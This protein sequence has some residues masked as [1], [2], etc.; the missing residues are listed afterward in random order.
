MVDV[1]CSKRQDFIYLKLFSPSVT[2][3]VIHRLG[4]RLG[5]CFCFRRGVRRTPAP[6]TQGRQ[7]FAQTIGGGNDLTFLLCLNKGNLQTFQRG[8]FYGIGGSAFFTVKYRY[9]LCGM[10]YH[11]FI[12]CLKTIFTV[13]GTYVFNIIRRF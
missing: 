4:C 3:Y 9:N 10:I 7:F 11:P 1:G 12:S 5:R 13:F 8:V 6:L 2:A